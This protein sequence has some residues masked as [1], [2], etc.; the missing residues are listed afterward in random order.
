MKEILIITS[1]PDPHVDAV[2]TH[3]GDKVIVRIFDPLQFPEKVR[4]SLNPLGNETEIL[5]ND[6]DI[7]NTS[8]VWYRKP[9]FKKPEEY[10]V[11]EEY[12]HY[13]DSSIRTICI[14]LYTALQNAFWVSGYWEIKKSSNKPYQLGLATRLGFRVPDTLVTSTSEDAL[15]FVRRY[16][17]NVITKPLGYGYAHSPEN[18]EFYSYFYATSLTG[19]TES[20]LIEE[21]QGLSLAPA[22]FQ[23]EIYGGLDIRVTVIGNELFPCEIHKISSTGEY[24]TD[25]RQEILTE[26]LDYR[27]HRMPEKLGL[28]CKSL[29]KELGLKFGVIEFVLDQEGNY[30]F[31]E[32]NPNGQWL[33][34]E[35]A[36]P[37][38]TIA[39]GLAD[40]L[41]A[42]A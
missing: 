20:T 9:R 26:Q 30:W 41:I 27:V 13:V 42:N 6:I 38:L 12:F 2:T 4:V 34:I 22:I 14:S 35:N 31:M 28:M 40:F 19:I 7:S 8:L 21:L 32:I 17:G 16:K 24:V 10:L 29:V 18:E 25:W 5:L 37:D 33:F 3:L 11:E 15:E 36:C 1:D 23:K 39:K